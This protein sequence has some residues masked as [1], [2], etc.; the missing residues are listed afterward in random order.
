MLTGIP[1]VGGSRKVKS[2]VQHALKI[3]SE[4]TPF[5]LSQKTAVSPEP[6]DSGE[7]KEQEYQ[8]NSPKNVPRRQYS[9]TRTALVPPTDDSALES[10]DFLS[11][12]ESTSTLS[13]IAEKSTS[14][15]SSLIVEPF[16]N[17]VITPT[18]TPQLGN[19]WQALRSVQ[20]RTLLY[21]SMVAVM[22]SL[23]FGY[24]IGYSSPTLHDL[25]A[26]EGKHTYFRK[27]IYHDLFNVSYSVKI[28]YYTTFIMFT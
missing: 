2:H 13:S 24:G 15:V 1:K 12:A 6:S 3:M 5:T 19:L 11:N 17:V 25:D 16:S 26:N 8:F 4:R 18:T 14:L 23:S 28:L 21:S 10:A 22:A 20:I 27:T 7:D 9:P